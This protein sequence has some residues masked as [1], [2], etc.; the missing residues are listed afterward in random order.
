MV[1]AQ[2]LTDASWTWATI[3]HPGNAPVNPA[4]LPDNSAFVPNGHAPFSGWGSVSS[5]YRISTTETT[6]SQWLP[7]VKAYAPYLTSNPGT[8]FLG[9]NAI[10]QSGP[11]NDPNSYSILPGFENDAIDSNFKFGAMYCNWLQNRQTQSQASFNSGVYDLTNVPVDSQGRWLTIP[12][13]SPSAQYWVPSMNEWVKAAFYDPNRYGQG[14]AGYWAYPNSS[15]QPL[16]SGMPQNG[17]Q[18]QYGMGPNDP[19]A[20]LL[21]VGAYPSVASP[22]GLLDASGGVAE[23]TDTILHGQF[24]DHV[25]VRNSESFGIGRLGGSDWDDIGDYGFHQPDVFGG[26]GFRLASSIPSPGAG[27]GLGWIMYVYSRRRR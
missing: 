23:F 1:Q 4:L 17:G 15:D 3:T 10:R 14:L 25:L 21:A 27:L 20:G 19:T 2:P 13:R 11:R 18:T 26:Y 9:G 22:W 6:T 16:I 5:I 7:F 12:S 8:E 24:F